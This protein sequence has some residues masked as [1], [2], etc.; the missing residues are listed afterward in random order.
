M[1]G[2][3]IYL[4]VCG[5]PSVD[6]FTAEWGDARFASPSYPAPASITRLAAETA[7]AT[8]GMLASL[9]PLADGSPK[10]TALR[11]AYAAS[12]RSLG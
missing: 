12:I 6:S 9:G 8:P 1:A 2:L 5:V 10:L 3:L 4:C 11:S 7:L